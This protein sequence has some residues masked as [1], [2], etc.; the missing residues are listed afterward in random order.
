M[1][2]PIFNMYYARTLLQMPLDQFKVSMTHLIFN[3][4][5][6]RTLLQKPLDQFKVSMTHSL[7]KQS[8]TTHIFTG[9]KLGVVNL[10]GR[11]QNILQLFQIS[12]GNNVVDSVDFGHILWNFLQKAQ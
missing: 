9:Q 12:F 10:V 3:M 7:M 2:H 6:A 4:Y 11:V 8:F 1:T 5:Y